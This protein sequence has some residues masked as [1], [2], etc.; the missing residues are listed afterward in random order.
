MS[1]LDF[2]DDDPKRRNR[3]PLLFFVAATLMVGALGSAIT[4]PSIP[5]WY[6]GLNRPAFAPPN[7]IFAPVWTSLY[8]AMAVAA[9]RVWKARGL[10]SLEMRLYAFQLLL[11]LTWSVIFFGLHRI[12]L[13][14][15]E[16]AAL[17]LAILATMIV[18][19]RADRIAGL[20]LLPYL[21]WTGFAA[22]LNFAFWQLNP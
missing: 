22:M 12:D 21:A 20:L 4:G 19:F 13:A 10:A 9:W 2:P 3:R 6:S 16:I 15:G 1:F 14:L 17:W 5:T 7:W 8:V 11:N 18:F